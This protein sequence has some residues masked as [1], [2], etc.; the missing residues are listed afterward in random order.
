MDYILNLNN[1]NILGKNITTG[2][3]SYKVHLD[4]QSDT[5]ILD[6]SIMSVDNCVDNVFFFEDVPWFKM[7]S[8][9]TTFIKTN[10]LG[11]KDASLFTL[12]II[13]KTKIPKNLFTDI[14]GSN[15]IEIIE[16]S[17]LVDSYVHDLDLVSRFLEYFVRNNIVNTENNAI[18]SGIKE[19]YKDIYIKKY[20]FNSFTDDELLQLYFDNSSCKTVLESERII[21]SKDNIDEIFTKL[22]ISVMLTA[23][24]EY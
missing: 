1:K 18:V 13:T 7:K 3:Y 6:N 15:F 14:Y 8:G 4:I 10:G 24:K 17:I 5:F 12:K 9:K 23:E 21:S 16:E 19:R 11:I 22:N 2:L 20:Q